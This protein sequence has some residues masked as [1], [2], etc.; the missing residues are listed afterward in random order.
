MYHVCKGDAV[1]VKARIRATISGLLQPYVETLHRGQQ[2]PAREKR[3]S[4]AACPHFEG[5]K[6]QLNIPSADSDTCGVY[7]IIAGNRYGRNT[8]DF[9]V[10]VYGK[11]FINRHYRLDVPDKSFHVC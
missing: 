7:T 5:D 1:A 8:E 2:I 4:Q 3:E 9:T 11:Y 6:Y 10:M